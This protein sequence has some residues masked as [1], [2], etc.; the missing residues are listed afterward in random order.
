MRA[1]PIGRTTP[2]QPYV[3]GGI[4]FYRWQY[5]EAGE[6]IDF[7]DDTLPVFV[8]TF[9]DDGTATGGL[10]LFGV[11]VPIGQFNVGGEARWQGG[12]AD[13]APE[14][15]FAGDKLDLGGWTAA[16]TFHV[17]F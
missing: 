1:F 6:F 12:S 8:D 7:S 9:T 4:N 2:V 13:L 14:L 16:A 3:G 15:N 17:R 5:R 10:M 11:R